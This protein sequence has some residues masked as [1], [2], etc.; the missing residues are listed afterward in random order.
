MVNI[1]ESIVF[2]IFLSEIMNVVNYVRS[3]AKN[4]ECL[5]NCVK[6]IE[7]SNKRRSFILNFVGF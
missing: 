7:A 5:S 3:R 2:E 6:K 4:A 1:G